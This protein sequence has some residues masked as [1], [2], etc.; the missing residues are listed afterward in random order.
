MIPNVPPRVRL[1]VAYVGAGFHGWQIQP[2]Q[3]T[4]QGEIAVALERLLQR[5]CLPT[6]AGRTDTGVHARGQVAHVELLGAVEVARVRGGLHKI[7]KDDIH[8][9]RTREVSP[10][11][12]ARFSATARRYSYRM[13]WTR[14]IFD[15]HAFHVYRRIDRAAMDAACEQ[16]L[17]ARDF[18]SFCKTDSL[19][20]DNTCDVDRC[21][22]EWSDQGCIFH[23]RANRFLH[24]MVRNLIGTVLEVGYGNRRPEDIALILAAHDRRAADK[25]VPAHGL[26]LEEVSY[27]ESLL[28]PEYLPPDFNPRP[29]EA[30]QGDPA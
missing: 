17:G 19:K 4:V 13:R 24:H 7:L 14:D 1:D 29:C 28:D 12:S 5:P 23:I 2:A 26:Y 11:F 25:M 6:G 30:D 18:S 20:D 9:L 27:P 15:P 16:I 3:R 21:A 8:I 22:L 10:G